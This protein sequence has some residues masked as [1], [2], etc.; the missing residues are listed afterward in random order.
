LSRVAEIYESTHNFGR[1]SIE[2]EPPPAPE[3]TLF[4]GLG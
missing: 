1:R 2:P 4:D 3:P